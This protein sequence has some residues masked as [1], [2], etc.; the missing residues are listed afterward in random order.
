MHNIIKFKEQ[1][2][3]YFHT[4]WRRYE[5]SSVGDSWI[6]IKNKCQ[7]V[8]AAVNRSFRFAGRVAELFQFKN[9]CTFS[10]SCENNIYK[11]RQKIKK[12][13]KWCQ[14]KF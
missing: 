12:I 6:R 8:R 7:N 5:E 3:Q 2:Q 4:C 14:R 1:D 13:Q 9:I 10:Y 11:N